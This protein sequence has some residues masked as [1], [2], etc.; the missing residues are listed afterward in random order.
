MKT[1]I[2]GSISGQDASAIASLSV[3]AAAPMRQ[4]VL[5]RMSHSRFLRKYLG[6]PHLLVKRWIWSHLP[7]W[8]T[9]GR[10]VRAYGV[11]LHALIQ[12]RSTRKQYVGTFFFR[13]RHELE[14]L[15]R[16]LDQKCDGSTLDLAVLACSKGAEVYSI[17]YAIRCARPDLKVSLRAIDIDKDVL[18]F[19]E[20][21]VYSLRRDAASGPSSPSSCAQS[22]DVDANTFR[23]QGISI[24]ERMSSMEMEA[25]FDGEGNQVK[26]KPRFRE[27]IT[28]HLGDAGDPDLVNALGL[29]DIVVANRFLCHMHS[30]EAEACLRNVARLVKPGG[31]L[32]VSGVDL[33]VR[34]RVAR[35]LGWKP[36]TELISEI[37]EGDPSLRRD[38]PLE[39]WGLE[40]F[41]QS[42]SDWKMRYA[43]VFQCGRRC[44]QRL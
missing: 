29:Q 17:S 10:L 3:P 18:N 11:Y 35:E 12:S 40:P 21:G 42:R 24:V 43:A 14:L 13:N 7:A 20:Q 8:L 44:E 9:S 19:A 5:D 41:D 37:H 38:W 6:R 1:S 31:Y 2:G 25:M 23:D 33:G 4:N 34:S 27:G 22:V 39:Y 26:V 16:L 36:V 15:I 30:E 32:F 28:W